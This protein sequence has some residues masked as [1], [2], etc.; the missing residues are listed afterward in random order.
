MG[1]D[2]RLPGLPHLVRVMGCGWKSTRNLVSYATACIF[3]NE[4]MIVFPDQFGIRLDDHIHM[5]AGAVMV[6][7]TGQRSPLSLCVIAS[8][9]AIFERIVNAR[10]PLPRSDNGQG[11]P[12]L[13]VKEMHLVHV[14][15]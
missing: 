1:P 11:T 14:E 15:G 13:R 6:C 12:G 7:D 2:H 10:P 3:S 9:L 8:A 4:P 5:T